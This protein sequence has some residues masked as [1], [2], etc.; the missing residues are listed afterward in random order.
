M[1]TGFWNENAGKMHCHNSLASKNPK[2][3]VIVYIIM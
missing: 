1:E 3:I 2:K